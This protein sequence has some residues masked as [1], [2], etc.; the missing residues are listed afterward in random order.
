MERRRTKEK[1][2]KIR[3]T[4]RIAVCS[5]DMTDKLGHLQKQNGKDLATQDTQQHGQRV[6]RGVS[7][8]HRLAVRLAMVSLFRM[9][10]SA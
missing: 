4:G 5:Y 6:D 9:I 8:V 7:D 1:C 2:Q 3:K 10:V